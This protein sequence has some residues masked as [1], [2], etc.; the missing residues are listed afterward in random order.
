MVQVMKRVTVYAILVVT[1]LFAAVMAARAASGGHLRAARATY[2]AE[3]T[4][5]TLSF[6]GDVSFD[7]A[8]Y[9]FTAASAEITIAKPEPDALET[10]L[11]S[12]VLSGGV[13]VT[14]PSGGRLNAPEIMA[15]KIGR[16]YDFTGAIAYTEGDLQVKAGGFVF[17][18]SSNTVAAT[19]KVEATYNSPRGFRGKDGKDHPMVYRGGN[20]IYERGEG[21]IRNAGGTRPTAEF[22]GFIFSAGELEFS[23]TDEG[24]VGLASAGD[25]AIQGRG[26]TISGMNA[27][28]N[29]DTGGLRIWG[30]VRYTRGGDE[31]AAEDVTW[32]VA[33]QGNRITVKGGSGTVGIGRNDETGDAAPADAVE[34]SSGSG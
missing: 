31:F 27:D 5:S 19:G 4:T 30:D 1:A 24:I 16:N 28:Y 9:H 6:E 25:I 11:K 13:L 14:T 22:D 21:T 32:H 17:D 34:N 18:G 10:D 15:G 7:Y 26:I 33:E 29:S 3:E 23:F 8:G 12:A 2:Y 20:L